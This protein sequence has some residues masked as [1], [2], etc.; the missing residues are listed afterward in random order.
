MT[1]KNRD[2]V[3]AMAVARPEERDEGGEPGCRPSAPPAMFIAF[4]WNSSAF[5]SIAVSIP[6]RVIISSVKTKTPQNA[7]GAGLDR[8]GGQLAFDVL[9]HVPP[10]A[11]HVDRQRGDQE[12]G[13]DAEDAFPQRL[14]ARLGEQ[15]AGADAERDRGARCPSEWP[16]T[17]AARP[18]LR[19]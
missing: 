13:D 4:T 18:V 1:W 7:R 19:R 15:H 2:E 9:L 3:H 17:S 10:G 11:P 5:I 6:S 16:G 12:G 14:V 8:R